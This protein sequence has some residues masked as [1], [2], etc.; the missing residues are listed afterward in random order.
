MQI[1]TK[2]FDGIGVYLPSDLEIPEQ[3]QHWADD[4]LL[5]LRIPA[6]GDT[7][8]LAEVLKAFRS[9]AAMQSGGTGF[10]VNLLKAYHSQ[11]PFFDAPFASQIR[12]DISRRMAPSSIKEEQKAAPDRLLSARIFLSVAQQL[13]ELAD[14]LD[15]DFAAVDAHQ[16]D[17]LREL[18][19][20]LPD[21]PA[22]ES[23]ATV[24]S[25]EHGR[26]MLTERMQAWAWLAAVDAAQ[27]GS[28]APALLVT[29]G[30][31]VLEW[32]ID[33]LPDDVI[34]DRSELFTVS[35]ESSE[36]MD[37]WRRDF[38]QA[39]TTLAAGPDEPVDLMRR[40]PDPPPVGV[41]QDRLQ[42][43]VIRLP[44]MCM[45]EVLG[46]SPL[47]QPTAEQA[48]A[49]AENTVIVVVDSAAAL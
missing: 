46:A 39:I 22:N 28:D 2:V 37:G 19:D 44:R 18:Q 25:E 5:E 10:D 11:T 29:A 7:E 48:G 4:N 36:A 41:N 6:P 16:K 33:R 26:Y 23:P 8:R 43:V 1:L 45:D 35:A 13:D 24:G 32:V 49:A 3:M 15:K 27:S 42:V 21:S 20:S 38:L 30:R 14:T 40:L 9:W 34:V 47:S 12:T 17:M 31:E